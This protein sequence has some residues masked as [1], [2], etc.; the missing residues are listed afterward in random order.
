M[1]GC[2]LLS[3]CA[4]GGGLVCGGTPSGGWSGPVVANDTIYV[5]TM[6]GRVI[7]IN[8]SSRIAG[9]PFPSVGEWSFS[10]GGGVGGGF[11]SCAPAAVVSIYGTPAV[12][13]G[14]VYIGTGNGKLYALDATAGYD[15]W[16]YPRD[17]YIGSIVGSPVV[18]DGILYIGS[19]DGKLYAIDIETRNLKR[20][21]ETGGEIW[22]TPLVHD[23][24]VYIGSADHK[25]YALDAESG[26]EVWDT[27]FV[28]GGAIAATPLIYNDTIYIGSFDRNFYAL[29]LDGT[30]KWEKPFSAGNWFWGKAVAY[31]DIIIVGCLDHKIYALDAESGAEAWPPYETGGPIRGDPVLLGDLVIFG[32]EDGKVYALE[33]AT[34]VERWQRDLESP[35]LA[36]IYAGDGV[37][38]VHATNQKNYALETEHG[39]VLWSVSPSK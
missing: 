8:P 34:G 23:G 15:I 9:Y 18:A 21:F 10:F 38:Y 31:G 35:I 13:D 22:G 1:A 29:N 17:G 20:D 11:L 12:A 37:V 4:P 6:D 36:S 3:G 24:V 16:Q 5:G 14:V 26:E 32:S 2:L 7:A 39:N 33:A 25:L 19:S 27:P 28:T 30:P